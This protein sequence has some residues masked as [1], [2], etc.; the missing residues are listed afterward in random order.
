VKVDKGQY[1]QQRPGD[2]QRGAGRQQAAQG[3]AGQHFRIEV[4]LGEVG[5]GAPSNTVNEQRR[6]GQPQPPAAQDRLARHHPAAHE[7]QQADYQ[8]TQVWVDI[9]Q[10]RERIEACTGGILAPNELPKVVHRR[11]LRTT[12]TTAVILPQTGFAAKTG[13]EP[14]PGWTGAIQQTKVVKS[15]FAARNEVQPCVQS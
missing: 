11:L 1:R 14:G 5:M 2:T 9:L 3:D 4:V 15:R 10:Q 6:Q 12:S 13:L 7:D 8:G